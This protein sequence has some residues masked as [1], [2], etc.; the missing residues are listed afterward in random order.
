L[1]LGDKQKLGVEP[2]TADLSTRLEDAMLVRAWSM[3]D[4]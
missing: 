3:F 4:N 2:W 1:K